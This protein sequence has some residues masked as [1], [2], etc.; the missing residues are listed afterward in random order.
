VSFHVPHDRRIL[1]G[2]LASDDS[3]GNNGA[4]DVP[5]IIGD[6]ALM[7]I[8][9]DGLGWEHVSVH[10]DEKGKPRTPTWTEMCGIK[11]LFWDEEDVVVQYHPRRSQYRN[12][13]QHTLHLWRPI[14]VEMPT[15]DPLMVA[16]A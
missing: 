3:V 13:H 12:L 16:P 4:F 7:V 5:A 2:P 11:D 15:P 14:G 6:R 9:S 10:V 8:A 1:R